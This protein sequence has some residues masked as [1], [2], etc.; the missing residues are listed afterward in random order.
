MK[1]V[2]SILMAVL[3]LM[4][5]FAVVA[6]AESTDTNCI[7]FQVPTASSVAWKNF[8]NVY[9]HIWE[10]GGDGFFSWQSKDEKCTDLGNGY[11]SYDLSSFEFKED[12]KYAV[13]FSNDNGLQTYDLTL[14]SDCKGDYV[15]CNGDTCKNP[16]DSAKSCAVA[17]WKNNSDKAFPCARED[18]EGILND[19]DS[20]TGKDVNLNFGSSAGKA[21]ALDEVKI[22]ETTQKTTEK[23]SNSKTTS[24]Q[25]QRNNSTLY[26][27]L[28]IIA[29]VVIVAVIVIVVW[30]S[31]KRKK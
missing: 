21:V 25:Q 26:I 22:E 7:Y 10:E 9:C 20:I 6:N 30:V 31:K 15:Y 29:V 24:T 5:S 17:R 28:A 2:I 14:T 11:F 23:A 16:V 8:S 27:L 4:F 12:G 18:S 19:P 1:K 13:I 3:V